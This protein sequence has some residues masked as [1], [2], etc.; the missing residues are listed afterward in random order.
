MAINYVGTCFSVDVQLLTDQTRDI[1]YMCNSIVYEYVNT[2][3]Y[4]G[5]EFFEQLDDKLNKH[6]SKHNLKS[7]IIDTDSGLDVKY[8]QG[9]VDEVAVIVESTYDYH[10]LSK[11][12]N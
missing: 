3:P 12:L 5:P 7:T 8:F 2:I 10:H 11:Q 9:F 4:N 1:S 6:L